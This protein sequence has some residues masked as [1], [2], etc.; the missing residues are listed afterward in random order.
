MLVL[1]LFPVRCVAIDK[2]FE[3]PLSTSPPW[4][5]PHTPFVIRS[6]QFSTGLESITANQRTIL[7]PMSTAL[8]ESFMAILIDGLS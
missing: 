8:L 3:S 7:R 4:S 1:A 6:C 5:K 2:I